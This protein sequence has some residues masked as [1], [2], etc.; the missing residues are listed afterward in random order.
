VAGV[1]R[2]PAERSSDAGDR[3]LRACYSDTLEDALRLL[4]AGDLP[5]RGAAYAGPVEI[6]YG[7]GSPFPVETSLDT[8]L[9]FPGG[10]ATGV[11][12]AGHFAWL[13]EPGCLADAL[14]RLAMRL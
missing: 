3:A 1:L 5:E 6:V 9:A 8:A 13:E 7:L 4:A 2:G 12:G 14:V 11:P 10:S